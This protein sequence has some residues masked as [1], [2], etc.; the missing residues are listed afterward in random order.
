MI[1]E[2]II[3]SLG[4]DGTAHIAPMGVIWRDGYPVLAPFRPST[5][6]DNLRHSG[7]AVINHTDDVRV[8]AGCLT[9]RRDWP[10]KPAERIDGRVL[11]AALAHQELRVERVEEDEQRPRFHCRVVHEAAHGTFKGFNRAQAAVIEA[12]ILVSRLHMLPRDKVEREMTYLEI[13][14]SKTAGPREREAWAWLT[15]RIAGFYR[16][17]AAESAR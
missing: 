12:A 8:F 15:G 2:S 17:A 10:L 3:T 16:D 9:G 1:I 4:A 11:A 14:V 5:T 6:L 7:G 13:A